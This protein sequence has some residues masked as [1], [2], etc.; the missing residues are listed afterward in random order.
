MR[1]VVARLNKKELE[2]YREIYIR[3]WVYQTGAVQVEYREVD[4]VVRSDLEWWL[5]I[6]EKY[7]LEDD[8][9]YEVNPINGVL[10]I[11]KD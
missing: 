2:A 8:E 11:D 3:E 7:D 1:E 5:R 9:F 4:S 6:Y 10:Y